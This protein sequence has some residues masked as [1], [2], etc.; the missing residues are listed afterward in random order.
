MAYLRHA[1]YHALPKHIMTKLHSFL[2]LL[3]LKRGLKIFFFNFFSNLKF[4]QFVPWVL[5]KARSGRALDPPRP[6]WCQRER[7][8]DPSRSFTS[9]KRIKPT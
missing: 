8:L 1:A 3:L 9:E 5:A 2:W 6:S 4:V 7:A